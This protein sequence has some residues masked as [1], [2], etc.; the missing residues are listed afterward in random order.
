MLLDP[1]VVPEVPPVAPEVPP[2][3]PE[4]PP[5]APEFGLFVAVEVDVGELGVVGLALV[6]LDAGAV[7]GGRSVWL[8][9]WS[10]WLG[11]A[12]APQLA[13]PAASAIILLPAAFRL[14]FV[15]AVLVADPV[16][17]AVAFAVAVAVPVAVVVP[18]AVPVGVAVWLA[19]PAGLV[20]ELAGATL[21]VTDLVG[22]AVGEEAVAAAGEEVGGHA[23]ALALLRPLVL[24]V[25]LITPFDE[26][27][28][29]LEPD[30]L[31]LGGALVLCEEMPVTWPSWIRASRVGGSA[32]ATPMANTAHAAARTGRSSPSR[33]SRGWRRAFPVLSRPGP[34]R[35]R[36]SRPAFQ[37]PLRPPRKPPA[38]PAPACLLAWADPDR[39]R[40]R[41]RWRPSGCGS[42]WS[43]AACRAW[44][45]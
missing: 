12:V 11:V 29:G 25:G 15:E 8:G 7:V 4:V 38:R 3:A 28:R 33:Q 10:V 27:P 34:V 44:R 30:P 21:G 23:G 18:V 22:L 17:R 5:V 31:R 13:V 19:P 1:P 42:T 20:A 32:R 43:A 9:G 39:T 24:L 16:A 40:A 45:R 14:A 6:D 37:R 36:P 35:S 26:A 41:I 2:V